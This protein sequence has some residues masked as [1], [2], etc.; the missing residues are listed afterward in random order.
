MK[1]KTRY[2]ITTTIIIISLII[3]LALGAITWIIQDTPD[4][5]NYKGS[6]ETSFMYNDEGEVITKLFTENRIY[7]PIN[8]IPDDLKNAIIAIEDTNFYVHHGID[9]W[10]ISRAIITNLMRGRFAQGGSTIT[11]QLARNA[12]LSLKKTFYRKI[13]E[14][15]LALQFERLYTK[16]EILEMYLNEILLGHSAYGVEAAAQ[17]Y[18]DK[19]VWELDLGESALIAGLPQAPNRYSPINNIEQAKRRRNIVLNRMEKL[20]YI[21]SEEAEKAKE[22]EIELNTSNPNGTNTAPYFVSHVREELKRILINL[23]GEDGPQMI[24]N[25]GLKVHTT[26][27]VDIQQKAED[28]VEEALIQEPEGKYYTEENFIPRVKKSGEKGELQPQVSLVTIDPKTGAIKSMIGGRGNDKYN[29]ATQAERQPG[30][31]FKPFV[32]TTALKQGYS[33]GS[34]INDMPVVLEDGSNNSYIPRNFQHNYRGFVTFREAL[35]ESI[36]IAAVKVLRDVGI[37][38]VINTAETM[39]ISTLQEEDGRETHFSLALGGLTSG[40]TP[41]EMAASYSVLANEGIKIK[42]YTIKKVMDKRGNV[43]YEANPQKQV[44]LPKDTSYLI[45]DMLQTVVKEGTGKN[46]NIDRPVAGKTGTT[47]N[48]TNAWFVGYTPD[49]VTSVWIGEDGSS[50]MHYDQKD[51]NGDYLYPE[52]GSNGYRVISSGEAA[53]LWGN[54]MEKVTADIP[55]TDF[56]KPKNIVTEEIDPVTGLLPN[57]YTPETKKEIFREDNTPQKKDS[58]HGP[59]ESIDIC[60]E[61]DALATS[62]CPEETVENYDFIKDS[63]IRINNGKTKRISFNGEI[64]DKFENSNIDSLSGTY[65]IRSGQP[66]QEIN[67][68]TGLPAVTTEK[69]VK[70]ENKPTRYCPTH[71]SGEKESDEDNNNNKGILDQIKDYFDTDD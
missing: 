52:P 8:R 5:S 70:Y 58:L 15:Y 21:T 22:Q 2:I 54:Y 24:Y 30:S 38:E 39:G 43:I 68:E 33:A 34:I 18:F 14:A 16:R 63:G 4:I 37:N 28:S 45:T 23:F 41:L 48:H 1:K 49:L 26:L 53:T 40:V 44:V 60:T 50:S 71:G 57:E 29:R 46:A 42:P 6:N 69:T 67:S 31:A 62:S 27:D 10:G 32:Y 25:G 20:G 19:H 3:G 36:N 59:V 65:I 35:K 11:Q 56:N 55:T 17:Q 7:V 66:V 61:S 9:L 51:E 47:N 12:L 64:P 13:Q